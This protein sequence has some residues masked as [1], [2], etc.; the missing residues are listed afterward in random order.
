MFLLCKNRE[1]AE[2]AAAAAAMRVAS[3]TAYKV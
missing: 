1:G 3:S 2:A